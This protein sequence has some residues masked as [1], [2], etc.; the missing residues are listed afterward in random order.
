MADMDIKEH[1]AL[2]RRDI[3]QLA[4][5]WANYDEDDADDAEQVILVLMWERHES[6]AYNH[7][8][9]NPHR[10]GEY[11]SLLGYVRPYLRGAALEEINEYKHFERD[12]KGRPILVVAPNGDYCGNDHDD[13]EH[14][15]T[16]LEGLQEQAQ[17]QGRDRRYLSLLYDE[18]MPGL[19]PP[20]EGGLSAEDLELAQ[21]LKAN[22]TPKELE[23]L[24]AIGGLGKLRD[25]EDNEGRSIHRAAESLNVPY[26]T[27]RYRLKNALAKARELARLYGRAVC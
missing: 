5:E 12:D 23:V 10:P 3:R 24:Y 16:N 22:L 19:R 8:W 14:C 2:H 27:Y 21:K 26:S 9:P 15:Y 17:E 13:G 18:P 11:V 25:A 20:I 4:L 7:H 1:L 6:G